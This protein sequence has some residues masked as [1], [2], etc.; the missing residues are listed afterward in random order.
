[1]DKITFITPAFAV[2]STVTHEDFERAAELGFHCVVS[3]LPDGEEE[4]ALT[5]RDEAV[6]AWRSGLAFAHIP[7]SKHDVLSDAVVE[8]M[9]DVLRKARGPVLAHCKSG[10]RSAILWAAAS[11][12]VKSVD[13]VLEATR[14]AGF[15]LE[16]LREELEQQANRKHWLGGASKTLDCGSWRKAPHGLM[17]GL[18]RGDVALL[19]AAAH[20]L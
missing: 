19:S 13:C 20:A 7:A 2:T 17:H 16:F 4:D 8:R 1:M 3:N 12:R 5:A 11:A 6:S 18:T 9:A 14:Q 15:D 10:T